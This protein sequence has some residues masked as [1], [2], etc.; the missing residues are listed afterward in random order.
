MRRPKWRVTT[1][2]ASVKRLSFI[3][4]YDCGPLDNIK[5]R[6]SDTPLP[7]LKV[8]EL[9]VNWY[10]PEVAEKNWVLCGGV[11]VA[12]LKRL[13]FIFSER[14]TSLMEVACLIRLCAPGL[15]ELNLEA[16]VSG[17]E[18]LSYP[19]DLSALPYLRTL[20]IGIP[21]FVGT[22]LHLGIPWIICVLFAIPPSNMI[23]QFELRVT[24]KSV[25]NP[26]GWADLVALLS[27]STHFPCLRQ[28]GFAVYLYKPFQPEKPLALL[29]NN[30]QGL[31]PSLVVS[32]EAP[33]LHRS[34]GMRV[35]FLEDPWFEDKQ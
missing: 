13:S 23:E 30:A 11:D 8:E 12:G 6:F 1:F 20:R 28:V 25:V 26:K 31:R 32:F 16:H 18:R 29:K 14:H 2:C 34:N 24:E 15:E 7:R 3:S 9:C 19:I 27:H 21:A 35:G 5:A 10:N 4:G 22:Y 33:P 17:A